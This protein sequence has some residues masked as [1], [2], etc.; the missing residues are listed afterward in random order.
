MEIRRRPLPDTDLL[1]DSRSAHVLSGAGSTLV[2]KGFDTPC[3]SFGVR[4]ALQRLELN[5]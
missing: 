3:I 4:L 5:R 1:Y 2:T